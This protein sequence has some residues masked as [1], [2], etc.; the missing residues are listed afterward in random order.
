MFVLFLCH[1]F[2][3]ISLRKGFSL[4]RAS[5]FWQGQMVSE[6]WGSIWLLL[7]HAGIIGAC[8]HVQH[9]M[10]VLGF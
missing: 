6:P 7:P 10:C 3:L 8:S 2:R 1:Y 4:T 5:L 9:F